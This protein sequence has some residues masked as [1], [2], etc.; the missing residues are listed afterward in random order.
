MSGAEG[1]Q[2]GVARV[3]GSPMRSG[4]GSRVPA[5]PI[6]PA[7]L[8]QAK[9]LAPP[10]PPGYLRRAAPRDVL[11][12][13]F[14]RRLTVLRAPG[15]FGK[16]AELAELYRTVTERGTAAGWLSL[17][18]DDTP[19]VFTSYFA[20]AL[21]HGGLEF[22]AIARF[23]GWLSAPF[24]RQFGLVAAAIEAHAAPCLIILDGVDRLPGATV[25]Q[26]GHF[27]DWSPGNL[28]FALA[29]RRNPGLDLVS[30]VLDGPAVVIG[31][32]RFR[33]SEAETARY[34]GGALTRRELARV[35][36]HSA[37]WPIALAI[38]KRD[39]ASPA[40][41]AGGRGADTSHDLLGLRLLRGVRAEDRARVL[42]LAVF[43]RLGADVVDEVLGSSD[44][45]RRVANLES[46]EGLFRPAGEGP[47]PMFMHPLVREFCAHRLQVEAPLRKRSLHTGIARALARRRRF[48]EAWFHAARA[49]DA[50][51][52][53]ELL[54]RTGV[55]GLWL[56]EGG[57]AVLAA[58]RALTSRIVQGDQRAAFLRS[59]QFQ[60]SA[61]PGEAAA[62]YQDAV[63]SAGGTRQSADTVEV[64]R[65]FVQLVLAGGWRHARGGAPEAWRCDA[66]VP[67]PPSELD[68]AVVGGRR[69]LCCVDS[70][71]KL[72]FEESRRY[73]QEAHGLFAGRLPYGEALA[74]IY[75]GMGAMAG[76]DAREAANRYQQAR[77]IAGA[78][79]AGNRH[80][81]VSL[82]V[83][84]A[85]L[86][87]ERNQWAPV[88]QRALRDLAALRGLCHETY[89]AGIGVRA[90]L[91]FR[92][93][94][95]VAAVRYLTATLDAVRETE[96]PALLVHAAGLL[97]YYLARSG[98][99]REA[100]QVWADHRLPCRVAELLDFKAG[101]WR[102]IEALASARVVLL[103][104]RGKLAEA[105]DLADRLWRTA[106]DAGLIRTALRGLGLSMAVASR[107]DEEDRALSRLAEL[108]RLTARARYYRALAAEADVSAPLLRRL[109]ANPSD[110]ELAEAAERA[111][112]QVVR[113][114]PAG[115]SPRALEV[116]AGVCAGRGTRE[117]ARR[118]G[119][120]EGGVRYHLRNIYRTL[121][122]SERRAAVRA[123][124]AHG[125]CG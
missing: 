74:S 76:G 2:N 88:G 49:E 56:R 14:E 16:T 67:E 105:A 82:H 4:A 83:L 109:L 114:L 73:G 46:L 17:D 120:S 69:L 8:L 106:A 92:G 54:E 21:D 38:D 5:S 86:D 70:Y 18:E 61:K 42:D 115:L 72:D 112:A 68:R 13:V 23:E 96:V 26:L 85:E 11:A 125:L 37:G 40:A 100:G 116:L 50:G 15:G 41:G 97:A 30:S 28:H 91:A 102:T 65:M 98:L 81:E 48:R 51:L 57:G 123:A 95:R 22:P 99:T 118:L 33:F 119:I 52:V 89:S 62:L 25:R 7:W 117:I 27:V 78:L 10:P 124:K 79:E 107:A 121:K 45:R 104:N 43:D 71:E 34:Y 94:E 12:S 111:L 66:A 53:E 24:A 59:V 35:V 101:P 6:G 60:L 55:F 58:G 77:Q 113:P 19:A 9:V 122:V 47:G 93:S 110:P 87:L 75:L 103:A 80:L 29:C 63:G 64:D 20:R 36:E 108:L 3:S 44:V 39:R 84:S 90:E 32:E 1:D 31:P